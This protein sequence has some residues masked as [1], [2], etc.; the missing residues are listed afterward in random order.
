MKIRKMSMKKRTR[1]G[2]EIVISAMVIG[3]LGNLM[4]RQTPWGLNAFL[5]V[6]A[7]TVGMVVL[8]KRHRP[9]LLTM[10]TLALQAAM[11]FFG[12]MFLFRSAEELLVFDTIAILVI[13]GVLV[14]SNFGVNQR[15]AGVFHYAGG[16]IWS[17]ITS[18]FGAVAVLGADINWKEMPG[19]R[20]SKTVFSVL[21][22][23]AIA[24]VRGML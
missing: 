19:N 3:V 15:I 11:V 7:F 24:I 6:T 17:G 13:M 22:G 4:L 23:V 5:F 20:I 9:E 10:R 12:A 2:L 21:R 18:A 1:T 8:T 14:L 16:F